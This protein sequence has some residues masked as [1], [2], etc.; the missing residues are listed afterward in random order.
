MSVSSGPIRKEILVEAPQERAFRVFTEKFDVWWPRDHH[1][2]KAE[3]KTAV[4]ECKQDGRFYEQS[5]DGTECN[6]GKVLVWE[7]P[8][9]LVLAWQISSQWQYDPNLLTEVEITFTQEGPK[10]TR[11]ELEHRNLERFGD[12]AQSMREMM[13]RGWE[14]TLG[15]FDKVAAG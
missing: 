1:I 8:R 4:L 15:L 13:G 7:P 5:V 14:R 10:R 11:V 3:M 2:G 12:A 6:W 9:R